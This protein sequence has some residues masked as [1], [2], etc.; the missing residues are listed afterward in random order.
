LS[1]SQT[2]VA[3]GMRIVS[4]M[5]TGSRNDGARPCGRAV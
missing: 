2:A 4:V 3:L 5:T 1:T